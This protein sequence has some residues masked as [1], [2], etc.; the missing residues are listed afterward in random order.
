MKRLRF[1]IPLFAC[2]VAIGCK[3]DTPLEGEPV[4][5]NAGGHTVTLQLGN[6]RVYKVERRL[7]STRKTRVLSTEFYLGFTACSRQSLIREGDYAIASLCKQAIGA[8]GGCASGGVY[9]TRDGEKW[10]KENHDGQWVPVDE[11]PSA[12]A[13]PAQTTP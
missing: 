4:Q 6:C 1:L 13:P 8:G 9:R 10:E 7:F 2:L 11:P 3:D 5:L 12:D